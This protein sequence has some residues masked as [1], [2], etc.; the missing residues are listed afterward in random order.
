MT[1]FECF[2]LFSF[3]FDLKGSTYKRKASRRE[4]AKASP[5]FKVSLNLNS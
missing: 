3:R 2:F 4:R 5:T 1:F